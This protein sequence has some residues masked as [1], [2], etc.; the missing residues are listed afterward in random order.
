MDRKVVGVS[1]EVVSGDVEG[2]AKGA[3]RHGD[4]SNLMNL[5]EARQCALLLDED[6]LWPLTHWVGGSDW[7]AQG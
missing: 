5:S 2:G 3:A 4:D 6:G 7:N 1:R